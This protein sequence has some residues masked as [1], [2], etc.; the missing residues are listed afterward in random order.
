[1]E[2]AERTQIGL[3]DEARARAWI[4]ARQACRQAGRQK[5]HQVLQMQRHGCAL[6]PITRL[7]EKVPGGSGKKGE[8][9]GRMQTKKKSRIQGRHSRRAM[10]AQGRQARQKGCNGQWGVD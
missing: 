6:L 4:L 9:V 7:R 2:V 8:R 5:E 1:V 3:S 10:D